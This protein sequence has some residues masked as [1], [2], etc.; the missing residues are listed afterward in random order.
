MMYL[1][2]ISFTFWMS[3]DLAQIK[4]GYELP[5]EHST[6]TPWVILYVDEV[7]SAKSSYL[8]VILCRVHPLNFREKRGACFQCL[9]C[10]SMKTTT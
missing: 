4:K 10:G 9:T 5:P 6:R 2:V 8:K 1:V 3:S 7:I